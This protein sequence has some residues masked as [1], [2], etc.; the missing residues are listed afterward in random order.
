MADAQV[1]GQPA[2]PAIVEQGIGR[3]LPGVAVQFAALLQRVAAIEVT[4]AGADIQAGGELIVAQGVYAQASGVTVERA[5][6]AAV[7]GVFA[8]HADFAVYASDL[9]AGR[10][11]GQ[12]TAIMQTHHSLMLALQVVLQV[13]RNGAA[14]R[15]G[16][17]QVGVG[18]LQH[19]AAE[20]A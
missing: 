14:R 15:G 17:Q 12:P 4:E 2:W 16:G 6:E 10:L 9:A 11:Q 18:Q 3:G 1:A 13:A 19:Q 8:V 5:V 20:Q 7:R